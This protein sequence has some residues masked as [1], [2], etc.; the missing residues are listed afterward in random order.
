[1]GVRSEITLRLG[2]GSDAEAIAELTV[3]SWRFAYRGVLPPA[4]LEGMAVGSRVARWRVRLEEPDAR[5]CVVVAEEAGEVTGFAWFGVGSAHPLRPSTEDVG[6]IYAFYLDPSRFGSGLA[7]T[8]A[9]RTEGWL[10]A[11]FE[12]SILWVLEGNDRARRFYT[13]R[14]WLADGARTPYPKPGCPGVH[15]VRHSWSPE[16]ADARRKPGV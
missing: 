16:V 1:M 14:G 8:L 10:S 11:R 5:W 12:R 9:E 6:E 15:I 4:V 2:V 13:R 7:D 3:R